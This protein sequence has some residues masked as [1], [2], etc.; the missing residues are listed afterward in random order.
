M[1]KD[2]KSI[3]NGTV[4]F[5]NAEIGKAYIMELI[6]GAIISGCL[7]SK[8]EFLKENGLVQA[9]TIAFNN[10]K[11][12]DI[13]IDEI[14]RMDLVEHHNENH[15]S[16]LEYLKDFQEKHKV[17]CFDENG[18]LLSN[19]TILGEAVIGKK[20][21]DDL[22]EKEKNEF[23]EKV[24][25]TVEN[26]VEVINTSVKYMKENSRLHES[27]LRMLDEA[28]K[29]MDRYKEAQEKY[30]NINKIYEVFFNDLR[31]RELLNAI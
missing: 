21:W 30:Q 19:S 24:G 18:E 7:V 12:V 1:S 8:Y 13:Q 5:E 17:K 9:F 26:I 3:I 6:S 11:T 20:I 15:K 4:N 14:S 29:L 27:R 10:H 31:I 28:T 23:I 22:Q 16:V 25:L 2:E